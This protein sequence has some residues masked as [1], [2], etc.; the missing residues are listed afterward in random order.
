MCF[1]LATLIVCPKLRVVHPLIFVCGDDGSRTHTPLTGHKGLNLACLPVPPHP[2]DIT[3]FVPL[4]GLEPT[5]YFSS[6]PCKG[7]M[8]AATPQ[9]NVWWLLTPSHSDKVPYFYVIA[10]ICA[11]TLWPLFF[12]KRL[13]SFARLFLMFLGINFLHF[14]G[15]L[16]LFIIE[17]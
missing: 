17:C 12:K 15:I 14:F 11:V 4:V 6:L 13:I 8:F 1:N 3:F 2:R 5:L 10:I 9:R 7:R 16:L